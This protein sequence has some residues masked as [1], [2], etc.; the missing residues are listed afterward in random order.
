M[1][2]E[3]ISTFSQ[4]AL[5][6]R[7]IICSPIKG[8]FRDWLL[9]SL[10]IEH[11]PIED[12]LLLGKGTFMILLSSE[13]KALSLLERSPLPFQNKLF[14][15]VKWNQG[16]DM[17]T[18]EDRCKVPRF[19]VKLSFPGL[20]PKFRV[21][22]VLQQFG[23]ICGTPFQ[24]SIQLQ[25]S[26]PSIK[27]AALPSMVFPELIRYE[28][29]EVLFSQ[30][31]IVTGRPNQCLRCS[32]LGHLVKDCPKAQNRFGPPRARHPPPHQGTSRAVQSRQVVEQSPALSQSGSS[33]SSRH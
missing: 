8:V 28:W 33:G 1:V 2:F 6:G 16:F 27:V 5:I 30:R 31:V 12:V 3:R 10:A 9:A 24:D 19:P 18:F 22:Q 25:S 13:E 20:P 23:S 17:A 15:F 21:P 29:E 11:G 4:R 32:V 14:F 7:L 26:I